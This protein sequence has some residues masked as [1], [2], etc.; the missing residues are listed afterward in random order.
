[1]PLYK[2]KMPFC[3]SNSLVMPKALTFLISETKYGRANEIDLSIF[4]QA[5]VPDSRPAAR[6]EA[7]TRPAS[8]NWIL[9]SSIGVVTMI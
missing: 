1:M 6:S 7:A 8:C 9:S 5:L 2:P 3:F 4:G